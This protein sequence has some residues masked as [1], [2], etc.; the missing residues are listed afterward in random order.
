MN[1]WG[2]RHSPPCFTNPTT[3]LPRRI[4]AYR[5]ADADAVIRLD[6]LHS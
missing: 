2:K 5:I 6:P 3:S 4:P 1:A